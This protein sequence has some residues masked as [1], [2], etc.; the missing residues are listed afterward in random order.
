M[1]MRL[2]PLS[3]T[4]IMYID[5]C[6]VKKG[7]DYAEIDFSK[8]VG[9]MMSECLLRFISQLYALARTSE[10]RLHGI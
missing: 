4:C 8:D 5:A 9:T 10:R 2:T 7:I 3:W 6:L 1:Q